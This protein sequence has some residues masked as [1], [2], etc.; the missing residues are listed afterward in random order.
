MAQEGKF[1]K[2]HKW[3]TKNGLNKSAK[4]NNLSFEDILELEL[5]SV[6]NLFKEL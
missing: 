4:T 2:R 5:D 6:R 1:E 3:L